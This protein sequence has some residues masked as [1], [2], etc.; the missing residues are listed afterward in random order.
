VKHE[1]P[2]PRIEISFDNLLHN[3]AEVRS[4]LPAG[5]SI[6]AVVKDCA[7]GCGSGPVAKTLEIQGNVGYFAVCRPTEALYLRQYGISSPILIFGPSRKQD[8]KTGHRENF[9]FVLN[10]LSDLALWK[11]AGVPVRFHCN[12]DTR[13]HRMGIL[14][15]E[16]DLLAKQ[17]K[18]LPKFELE[19]VFTH[20]ANADEPRTKTVAQQQAVFA[21]SLA[22]LKQNGIIPRHIHYANSAALMRFDLPGCTLVRPGIALY[23]CRPDPAQNFPLDLRPV[24]SLKSS[25]VKI[26]KVPANTP[27]SYGGNYVT[28]RSTIIATVALGYAHGLPRSLGNKK[29]S[30]LICGKRFPIV[31]NVTM[32]YIM[33]DVGPQP[34]CSVGDEVVAIGS[35]G[36]EKI[37]PDEMALLTGTISYEILTNLDTSIDRFYQLNGKVIKTE[38]GYIF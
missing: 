37:T 29:G 11:S 18:R 28:K 19:G 16:V 21:K 33:V 26:K 25:I 32:D 4:P 22:V 35:Q 15:S 5:V 3:L 8:I 34:G 10:D 27:V 9:T 12:I 31:G 23:G 24:A 17:L 7:Y 6:L 13:M 30:V 1:F 36:A 14:P 38:K 2:S 20:L